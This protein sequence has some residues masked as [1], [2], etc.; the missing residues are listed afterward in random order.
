MPLVRVTAVLAAVS[1]KVNASRL[2]RFGEFD[3]CHPEESCA[4]MVMDI[5]AEVCVCHWLKPRELKIPSNVSPLE[6]IPAVD[7]E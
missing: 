1:A 7:S 3:F 5:S 4:S 6:Q 2:A